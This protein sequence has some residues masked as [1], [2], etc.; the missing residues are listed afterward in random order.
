MN[1]S[2]GQQ[3]REP[4]V[5]RV[6]V[7]A[8]TAAVAAFSTL[9][10]VGVA[11]LGFASGDLGSE[12]S[13]SE[14]QWSVTSPRDVR[15]IATVSEQAAATP[16][17]AGSANAPG[18]TASS[19][20][21][22]SSAVASGNAPA[23]ATPSPS[24]TQGGAVVGESAPSRPVA[25]P[26]D[27]SG[28]AAPAP[29]QAGTS[30]P[31]GTGQLS[32]RLSFALLEQARQS[33][34]EG[35]QA[36]LRT[37]SPVDSEHLQRELSTSPALNA[38]VTDATS[39]A[40]ESSLRAAQEHSGPDVR[41]AVV[42]RAA[43]TEFRRVLPEELTRTVHPV[44]MAA[45]AETGAEVSP[46]MLDRALDDVT[47]DAAR[48]L[49]A[50]AVPQVRTQVAALVE[51]TAGEG[52]SAPTAAVTTGPGPDVTATHGPTD[53]KATDSGTTTD[54][55]TSDSGRSSGT[56]STGTSNDSSDPASGSRATSESSETN[57]RTPG[58]DPT[59]PTSTDPAPDGIDHVVVVPSTNEPSS[60]ESSSAEPSTP[61]PR[62]AEPATPDPATMQRSTGE[63]STAP[64]APSS[65]PESAPT[66][67][68]QTAPEPAPESASDSAPETAPETAPE[69]APER[70]P[71]AAP[72]TAPEAA[73]ETAPEAA[74]D[75]ARDAGSTVTDAPSSD[76]D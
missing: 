50:L 31:L 8:P 48:Q 24:V 19:Q 2:D 25:V 42:T 17:V 39:T 4:K 34:A 23:D 16:G 21:A 37:L 46:Q 30:A 10:L 74:P 57:Q 67:P 75:T 15:A 72:D 36:G 44:V 14:A 52:V 7:V 54:T 43:E 76:A 73:P 1:D 28:A 53:G 40:A 18:N 32:I 65:A 61:E 66:S 38:A 5:L 71:E 6:R 3:A 20:S 33:V 68:A 27:A 11:A 26:S 59:S 58:G 13:S 62:H 35:L 60:E 70:A 56:N 69:A 63:P 22:A 49:S 51:T 12:P 64:D 45:L 29:A 55:A 9:T 41:P 47:D